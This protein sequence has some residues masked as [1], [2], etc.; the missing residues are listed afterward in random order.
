MKLDCRRLGAEIDLLEL[1]RDAGSP[2]RIEGL[3]SVDLR[4][5]YSH[6]EARFRLDAVTAAR[7]AADAVSLE[8]GA[9][10]VRLSPLVLEG[11][12]IEIAIARGAHAAQR[13]AEGAATMTGAIASA[14][15][16]AERVE[17]ALASFASKIGS[18]AL[19][20]ARFTSADRDGMSVRTDRLVVQ[21]VEVAREAATIHLAAAEASGFTFQSKPSARLEV[22]RAELRDLR[23]QLGETVIDIGALRVRDL[24]FT[25]HPSGPPTVI[26]GAAEA[27]S[28]T[29]SGPWGTVTAESLSLEEGISFESGNLAIGSADVARAAVAVKLARGAGAPAGETAPA[30]APRT[31]AMSWSFLDGIS[32]RVHADVIVDAKVP[33]I[34]RR[35]ATHKLRVLIEDGALDFKALEHD[36]SLLEDAMLDFELEGD[37]LILEKDLPLIPFDNETLVAWPLDEEEKALAAANR[38]RLSTLARPE[39]QKRNAP[40]KKEK[41]GFELQRVDVDPLELELRLAG[42]AR[43]TLP[44]GATIDLGGEDSAAV[45]SISVGGAIRHRPNDTPEPGHVAG[46]IQGIRVGVRDLP[47]GDRHLAVASLSIEKVADARLD[48]EGLSPAAARAALSDI[49]VRSLHLRATRR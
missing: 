9:G 48:L 4:G 44:G 42:P 28:C 29:V 14:S 6:D 8:L 5:T 23:V 35:V 13:E 36:L 32:G 18:A 25:S 33:I 1:P 3:R 7:L 26:V 41:G 38:V 27:T 22:A 47:I 46:T 37:R 30:A 24:Q 19:E 49:H 15:A 45:R 17:V 10:H 43:L 20:A 39:V 12:G 11:P 21:R 31:A 34:K 2:H 40:A 16:R